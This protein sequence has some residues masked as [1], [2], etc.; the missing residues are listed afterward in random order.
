MELQP[1]VD[2]A[3]KQNGLTARAFLISFLS[4]H[5]CLVLPRL[6]NIPLGPL[7]LPCHYVLLQLVQFVP[8]RPLV[9]GL[10]LLQAFY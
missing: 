1:Q 8:Q 10:H 3:I 7:L 9:I 4:E 5:I 6:L 2:H